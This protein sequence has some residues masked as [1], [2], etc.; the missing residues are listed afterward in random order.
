MAARLQAA[1]S[2]G[3]PI[4]LRAHYGGGHGAAAGK[5]RLRSRWPTSQASTSG[6]SARPNSNHSARAGRELHRREPL[7]IFR[8][9]ARRC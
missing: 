8:L 7:I 6:S 1:T 9:I 4:L 5:R 3:K 2:S